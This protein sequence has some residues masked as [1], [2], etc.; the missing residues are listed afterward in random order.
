MQHSRERCPGSGSVIRVITRMEV[1]QCHMA[2]NLWKLSSSQYHADRRFDCLRGIRDGI[3]GLRSRE[4]DSGEKG[5][6]EVK[7][8]LCDYTGCECA[9]M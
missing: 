3:P 7:S 1:R 5:R 4:G 8:S 6:D 9:K 2:V